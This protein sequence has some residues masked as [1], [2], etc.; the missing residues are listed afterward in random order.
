MAFGRDARVVASRPR[1]ARPRTTRVPRRGE[2]R[3]GRPGRPARGA[4]PETASCPPA[5]ARND[6][7]AGTK[8]RPARSTRCT[9]CEVEHDELDI[10][11]VRRRCA[12]PLPPRRTRARPGARTPP[13][14]PPRHGSLRARPRSCGASSAS[15]RACR[16][17]ARALRSAHRAERGG[18]RGRARDRGIRSTPRTLFPRSSSRGEKTAM[19]RRPG[20]TPNTPP[21]TPLFAGNA[22]RD[23]PLAGAV[24]HAAGGHHAEHAAD[25]APRAPRARR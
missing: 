22:D 9:R 7:S 3:R 13:C 19:P 25:D 10:G 1:A 11:A 5:A 8:S 18:A 12:R 14:A 2:G 16:R 6:A 4:P 21:E 24:V 23:E 17:R 15:P 20:R